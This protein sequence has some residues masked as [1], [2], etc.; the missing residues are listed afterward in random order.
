MDFEGFRG[1]S[2]QSA[3]QTVSGRCQ[4]RL[5]RSPFP[6]RNLAFPWISKDFEGFRGRV[7]GK[8]FATESIPSPWTPSNQLKPRISKD[9]EAECRSIGFAAESIPSPWTPSDQL[10][11]R[12]SKDFEAQCRSI[13]FAAVRHAIKLI[14]VRDSRQGE[15]PSKASNFVGSALYGKHLPLS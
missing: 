14:S 11:P 15:D 7:P 5:G 13:G 4:D 8:P 2:R 1:I 12:I 9:F 3:G 10:K 6:L